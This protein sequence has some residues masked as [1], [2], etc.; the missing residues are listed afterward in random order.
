MSAQQRMMNNHT[1]FTITGQIRINLIGK[2]NQSLERP[3]HF[4]MLNGPNT[5]SR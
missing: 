2:K 4:N 5:K 3:S 1:G